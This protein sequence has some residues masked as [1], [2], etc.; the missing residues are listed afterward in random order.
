MPTSRLLISKF[1]N[2][3][4]TILA[5]SSIGNPTKSVPFHITARI[6]G[7]TLSLDFDSVVNKVTVSDGAG[8]FASGKVGILLSGGG[9]TTTRQVADNFSTKVQ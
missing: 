6:T 1:V 7:N 2:G 8:T 5:N 9:S 4:E 3:V